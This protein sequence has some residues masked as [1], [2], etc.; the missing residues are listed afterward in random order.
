MPLSVLAIDPGCEQSAWVLYDGTRVVSHNIEANELVEARLMNDKLRDDWAL[1]IEQITSYGMPVGVEVF[2]TVFWTGRFYAAAKTLCRIPHR[3]P[4]RD[5]KLHLC[6][7]ARAK[8]ANVRQ[9]LLDRFGGKEKA[10]G[11]KA[12]PG[13]LYGVKA[14]CWQ[15]LA[16]AVTWVDLH[17]TPLSVGD[18]EAK[19]ST[20]G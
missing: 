3:V 5:V 14:D 10:V 13:P 2:D 7:S 16:L 17:G 12:S 20:L 15:A 19:S 18:R 6:Q 1:V 9:A 8:D 11:R 4:R